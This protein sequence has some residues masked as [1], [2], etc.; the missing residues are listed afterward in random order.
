M[1]VMSYFERFL[2]PPERHSAIVDA[3]GLRCVPIRIGVEG[4]RVVHHS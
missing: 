3:L 4:S 2:A 1:A